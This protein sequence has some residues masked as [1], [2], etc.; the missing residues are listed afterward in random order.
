MKLGQVTLEWQVYVLFILIVSMV[1][2]VIAVS[3]LHFTRQQCTVDIIIY[4][5]FVRA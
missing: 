4:F 5:K 1:M 3:L 2:V